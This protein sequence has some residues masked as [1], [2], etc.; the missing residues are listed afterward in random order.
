MIIV[1]QWSHW[2]NIKVRRL[3]AN[4][5]IYNIKNISKKASFHTLEMI[6]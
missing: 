5:F 2:T 4:I 1:N 6:K 3:F